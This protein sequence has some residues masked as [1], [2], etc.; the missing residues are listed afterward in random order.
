MTR[1]RRPAACCNKPLLKAGCSRYDRRRAVVQDEHAHPT[2]LTLRCV[3]MACGKTVFRESGQTMSA[4]T[5]NVIWMLWLQ[6]WP[7]APEIVQACLRTWRF[8][9]PDYEI[10]ALTR[11]SVGEHLDAAAV[12]ELAAKKSMSAAALSDVIRLELLT[13][14]GG[15]WADST[16]YC[17]RPLSEWLPA[18]MTSGF[19]AFARPGPDRMLSNWFLAAQA[20]SPLVSVWRDFAYAYWAA[21]D[22]A[23]AYYWCHHQFAAGYAADEQFRATWDHTPKISADGPHFC[24][25]YATK[26]FWPVAAEDR[27]I[28]SEP[29]DA[30]P[31]LKLTHRFSDRERRSD[32]VYQFLLDRAAGLAR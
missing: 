23:G 8:H 29:S 30:R 14:H 21:R 13:R 32:S 9:N 20:E 17:L 27:A 11:E 25:P 3:S 4:T 12:F 10:R 5:P 1:I 6:G 7:Q 28:V 24:V 19:F 18:R 22:R 26:L 31:L 15:V 2:S 16:T